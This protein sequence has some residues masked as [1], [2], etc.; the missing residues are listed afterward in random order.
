[1]SS[2][3]VS[4]DEPLSKHDPDAV[5]ICL[6]VPKTGGQTMRR[7]VETNYEKNQTLACYPNNPKYADLDDLKSMSAEK[8]AELKVVVGHIDYGVHKYFDRPCRYFSMVRHPIER[9]IS[10]F[11]HVMRNNEVLAKKC[12]SLL[13][14]YEISP[15]RLFLDNFQTRMYSGQQPARGECTHEMLWTAIE[16]IEK[17]FDAV[18]TNEEYNRSV[19]VLGKLYGWPTTEYKKLNVTPDRQPRDSYSA[20]EIEYIEKW[21]QLDLALYDYVSSRFEKQ[22]MGMGI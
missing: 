5:L 21:N 4:F 14:F 8:K 11:Q 2:T 13:R 7:L 19:A 17:H 6:H 1:M 15:K 16:N 3:E 12:S 9:I 22:A 18:V 20:Y 10:S